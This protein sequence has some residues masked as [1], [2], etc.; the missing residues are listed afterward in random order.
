DGVLVSNFWGDT[1]D[2][3]PMMTR[4]YNAFHGNLWWCDASTSFNRI[5]FSGKNI[6]AAKFDLMLMK[7][8][9]RLDLHHDFSF[10]ELADRLRT[11]CGKN[12]AEFEAIAGAQTFA[13][14]MQAG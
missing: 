6:D 11:A 10:S 13:Q 8:A 2:L 4:L 1:A 7:R 5:V 9:A 3:V 12:L 14:A